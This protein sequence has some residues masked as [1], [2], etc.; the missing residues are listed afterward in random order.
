MIDTMLYH[1]LMDTIQLSREWMLLYVTPSNYLKAIELC[2]VWIVSTV[3]IV[4]YMWKIDQGLQNFVT[5]GSIF[6][7]GY[8]FY[9]FFHFCCYTLQG[10]IF[11]HLKIDCSLQAKKVVI[12]KMYNL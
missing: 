1:R 12:Y 2:R 5:F 9:T 10:L 11:I 8:R 3:H 4:D 6:C 7:Y